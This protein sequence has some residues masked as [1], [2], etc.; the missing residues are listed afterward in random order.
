MILRPPR[1]DAWHRTL[2]KRRKGITPRC[3]LRNCVTEGANSRN[4][5]LLTASLPFQPGDSS[6]TPEKQRNT[7]RFRNER[8]ESDIVPTV[9][10]VTD[11]E[12]LLESATRDNELLIFIQQVA[13][14]RKTGATGVSTEQARSV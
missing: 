1:Y 3:Q 5:R 6:K 12:V 4:G 13:A 8:C 14:I 9:R 11:L 7:A 2:Q 10:G